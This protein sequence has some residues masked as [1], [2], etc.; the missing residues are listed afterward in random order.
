M[1]ESVVGWRS[2]LY[3]QTLHRYTARPHAKKHLAD[4][5]QTSVRTDKG[6]CIFTKTKH[7]GRDDAEAVV[8]VLRAG[9]WVGVVYRAR[10][11]G[12]VVDRADAETGQ[13]GWSSEIRIFEP[14]RFAW[15]MFCVCRYASPSPTSTNFKSYSTTSCISP[16][17]PQSTTH[18]R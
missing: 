18:T 15:T 1:E 17:I 10:E 4:H 13:S 14:C 11:D 9:V 6:L 2:R 16:H 5:T 7:V 3:R 8:T 12:V